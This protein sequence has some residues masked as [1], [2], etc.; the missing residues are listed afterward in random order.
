MEDLDL[1]YQTVLKKIESFI[2]EYDYCEVLYIQLMFITI[3][4]FPELELKNINKLKLNKELIKIG[5]AKRYF[6]DSVL[7]LTMNIEYYGRKLIKTIVR[8]QKKEI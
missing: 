7:P 8:T 3:K 2:S 6:N 1:L 4:S 5:E